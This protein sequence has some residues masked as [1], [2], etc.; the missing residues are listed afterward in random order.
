MAVQIVELTSDESKLF[1]A[2]D[3]LIQK[4]LEH[5]RQLRRTGDAGNNAGQE[6]DKA[7][8]RVARANERDIGKL[9]ADLNRIGPEG[10]AAAESLKMA[11]REEG[12]FGFQNVDEIIQRIQQIDP[13]AAEAAEKARLEF[14]RADQQSQ[15]AK[16]L[17]SLRRL[18]PEGATI[19]AGIEKDLM[20]AETAA[21]GGMEAVIDKIRELKP[22]AAESA[23]RIKAELADAARFSEGQFEETLNQLRRMGP[24]GRQVAAELKQHL[25]DAGKIAERSISDVI[26]E[27]RKIDPAAAEAAA[28]LEAKLSGAANKAEGSWATFG[29]STLRQIT[30]VAGAY[31]GLQEGIQAVN[32]FLREQEEILERSLES[33]KTLAQAQQQAAKNLAGLALVERNQLLQ[34]SVPDIAADT[35]FADLTAITTALGAV[36]STGE[37]ITRNIDNAVR[38]AA[39]IELLTPEELSE[40]AQTAA[41]VQRQAGLD[42]VREAISVVETTGTQALVTEVGFLVSSLPRAIGAAVSTVPSQDRQEAVREAA[43]LFAQITQFGND[44]EGRRA[45]TFQADLTNRLRQFFEQLSDEQVKARSRVEVIDRKIDKGSDT[46]RDRLQ[47]QRLLEFLQQSEGV[48]DPQTLFGRIQLLQEREALGRQFVGERGFGEKQFQVALSELLQTGSRMTRA[49]QD[50]FKI[51]RADVEFFEREAE[52]L[53]RSTPQL[54][55]ST[56]GQRAAAATAAARGFDIEGAALAQVRQITSGA[57]EGSA[58]PGIDGFLTRTLE[59]TGISIGRLEGGTAIEEAVSGIARLQDRLALV[60]EG[61]VTVAEQP[62]V[63]ILEGAISAIEQLIRDV[64][65]SGEAQRTGIDEA[66]SLARRESRAIEFQQGFLDDRAAFDSFERNQATLERIADLLQQNLEANEQSATANQS[67]SRNTRQRPA[68]LDA[69]QSA[70]RP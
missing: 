28:E 43:A 51:I 49:M 57:L 69:I 5:E 21:A 44:R 20:E 66:A 46:E 10:Q 41:L 15:F 35:G 29:K 8:A 67:T 61:G 36:A 32:T 45:A 9:L 6:I 3:R 47:R 14:Q 54:A 55:L 17:A 2:L 38:Q 68:D 70:S 62:R 30:A 18:G 31:L 53:A 64:L 19:A 24:V 42:D 22:E 33:Q 39:R 65:L 63:Q 27:I 52:D 25:V 4:E 59:D 37:S 11:F 48:V 12:K 1:R 13:E 34:Q 50:S 56:A 23:E 58:L 16:T 26:D 40:T 60:E 7:L